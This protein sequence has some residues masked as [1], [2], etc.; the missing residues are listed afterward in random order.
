MSRAAEL[1]IEL[2]KRG[3]ELS[4]DQSGGI[5]YRGPKGA[6]SANLR[7]DLAVHRSAMVE[8]LETEA[9]FLALLR[10]MRDL[11]DTVE[12]LEKQGET[13]ISLQRSMEFAV[14]VENMGSP[15]PVESR[16]KA[17][18][19]PLWDEYWARMPVAVQ[20]ELMKVG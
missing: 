9:E 13:E 19:G 4:I 10:H 11:A 1:V 18:V 17:L 14:L 8:L 3:V 12:A 20:R 2:R 7:G 16:L 6:L 5:S 15:P